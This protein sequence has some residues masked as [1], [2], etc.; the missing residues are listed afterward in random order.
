MSSHLVHLAAFAGAI[1]FTHGWPTYAQGRL[2]AFVSVP[3]PTWRE[4]YPN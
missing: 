3:A 4:G 1:L 2:W